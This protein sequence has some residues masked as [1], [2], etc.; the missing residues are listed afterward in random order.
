MGTSVV[1]VVVVVGLR[2]LLR[3]LHNYYEQQENSGYHTFFDVHCSYCVFPQHV[4]HCWCGWVTN[5]S[6]SLVL[7]I[8][9]F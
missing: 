6:G 3:S 8:L 7:N 9:L 4:I 2:G 5:G 1:V